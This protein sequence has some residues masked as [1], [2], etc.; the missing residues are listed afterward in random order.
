MM[1][2]L[3]ALAGFA[4]ALAGTAAGAPPP[5]PTVVLVHGAFADSSSW[6]AVVAEL[7]RDHYSVIAAANP[8]RGAA[9]DAAYV[10]SIARSVRGPVV[11]VGHSYGGTVIS[12]A[13]AEAPNVKGLVFVSAFAPEVGETSFGLAGKFPGATLG[14]ALAAPVKTP[15]G[16]EDLY[17][18]P[19]RFPAQFAADVPLPKARLMAV[20]QRPITQAAGEEKARVAAWKDLPSWFIYGSKDL[21]IPPAAMAFMAKRAHARKVVVIHG[22]SHV[23]MISHPHEVARLIETAAAASTQTLVA[24]P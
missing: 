20:A 15:E 23:V 3:L 11:L 21:N 4:G 7:R 22:A 5:K 16:G 8:L 17:I 13:G 10:A 12:Q 14:A 2:H 18:R 6:N 24:L 1:R 9:S 19:E